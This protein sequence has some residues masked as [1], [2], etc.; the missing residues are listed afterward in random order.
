[1][2]HRNYASC[3]TQIPSKPPVYSELRKGGECVVL[4][5]C[6]WTWRNH[7]KRMVLIWMNLQCDGS[8]F[9]SFSTCRPNPNRACSQV[10]Y[11]HSQVG[12]S[13][14]GHSSSLMHIFFH[15]LVIQAHRLV[16]HRLVNYR[17]VIHRLVTYHRLV[18]SAKGTI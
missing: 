2:W 14:V 1:M 12:Y 15:M 17:L 6:T 11:S 5:I 4:D 3:R 16:S 18:I 9:D 7:R 8:V 13:D 10:G